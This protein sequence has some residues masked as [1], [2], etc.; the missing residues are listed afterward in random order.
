MCSDETCWRGRPA[1]SDDLMLFDMDWRKALWWEGS[2]MT[3]YLVRANGYVL[4]R[5]SAVHDVQGWDDSSSFGSLRRSL[6]WNKLR[7]LSHSCVQLVS[8]HQTRQCL[9]GDV[10]DMWYEKNASSIDYICEACLN[11]GY[12]FISP[13]YLTIYHKRKRLR[14]SGWD[15]KVC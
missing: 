2:W 7:V 15:A 14:L 5:R 8:V 1:F 11:G 9:T 3:N 12:Y 6:R 10:C 4:Y 13:N